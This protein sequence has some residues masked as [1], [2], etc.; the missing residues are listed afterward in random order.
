[1]AIVDEIDVSKLTDEQLAGFHCVRCDRGGSGPM[2]A[3]YDLVKGLTLYCHIGG[4]PEPKP[5]K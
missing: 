5:A 3:L 2:V 4:C 1:M